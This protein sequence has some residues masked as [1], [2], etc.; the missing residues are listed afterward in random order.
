LVVVAIIAILAS[1]LLPALA[2]ARARSQIAS[3]GNNMRQHGFAFALYAE[4]N[5]GY[6]VFRRGSPKVWY[7][8]IQPYIEDSPAYVTNDSGA[9][10]PMFDCVTNPRWRSGSGGTG[11]EYG[12]NKEMDPSNVATASGLRFEN[13]LW[14]ERK[15]LTFEAKTADMYGDG[16]TFGYLWHN[17]G[18]FL[19]AD[20]HVQYVGYPSLIFS[21]DANPG[22][23]IYTT[24]K[25]TWSW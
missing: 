1:I 4:E 7:A 24:L 20:L 9:R 8:L 18:N 5:D 6:I 14:P 17:G 25:P 10:H 13:I 11:R 19:L 15:V 16:R 12:M 22:G 23:C 21:G 3:C 2:K